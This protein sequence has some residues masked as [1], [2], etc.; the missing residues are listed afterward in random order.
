MFDARGG[1]ESKVLK[2]YMSMHTTA[3]AFTSQAYDGNGIKMNKYAINQNI[4]TDNT[5]YSGRLCMALRPC[6]VRND[7]VEVV[8]FDGRWK[9]RREPV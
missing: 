6:G 3:F 9:G 8:M 5:R 2:C 7:V 4:L 1:K